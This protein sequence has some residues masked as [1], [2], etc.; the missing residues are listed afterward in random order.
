MTLTLPDDPALEQIAECDI[1]LDLACGLYAAG[2][3]SRGIAARLAGLERMD[4]DEELFRRRIPSYTEEMLKE[5]L[6]TVNAL[7]S[8]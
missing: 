7:F 8:K 3:V 2:R 4:F 6:E 5:D 1:R